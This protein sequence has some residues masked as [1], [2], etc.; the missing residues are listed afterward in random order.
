MPEQHHK[1]QPA[2]D[3]IDPTNTPYGPH[4]GHVDEAAGGADSSPLEAEPTGKRLDEAKAPPNAPAP[5][6]PPRG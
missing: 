6:P 3:V 1:T 5:N 4:H 2:D